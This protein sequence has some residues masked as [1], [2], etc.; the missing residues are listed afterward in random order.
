MKKL[1]ITILC[2][3]A[4]LISGARN[5]RSAL[6]IRVSNFSDQ[7]AGFNFKYFKDESNAVDLIFSTNFNDGLTFTSIY[8]IHKA[9][10]EV[11]GLQWYYGIGFHVGAYE[12][13]NNAKFH[14]GPTGV[15]GLEFSVSEIPFAF[16]LDYMPS[17][18]FSTKRRDD[19][20]AFISTFNR[21][22]LGIKYTFGKSV[23]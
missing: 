1:S 16:S 6:G 19:E 20:V 18:D 8:E 22:T 21:F 14:F 5:Y 4:F 10:F 11:T 3:C 7:S 17:L 13:G 9:A 12:S 15:L 23:E 2:V